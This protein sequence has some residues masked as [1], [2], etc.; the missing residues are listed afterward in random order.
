V[1]LLRL[2]AQR[3]PE[4]SIVPR[5]AVPL[6]DTDTGTEEIGAATEV[7]SPTRLWGSDE[8]AP[9]RHVVPPE[10]LES[11]AGAL[12]AI[13]GPAARSI[14]VT[15]CHRG[16]GRST[17]ALA[18][19]LL[20]RTTCDRRTL[21]VDLDLERP[22]LASA[23]GISDGPGVAEVLRGETPVGRALAWTDHDLAVLSAGDSRGAPAALLARVAAGDLLDGL[24]ELFDT[25]VVDLPPLEGIGTGALV[26]RRC[27]TPLLVVRAGAV[28]RRDLEKAVS[29]F[30]VP[31]PILMNGVSPRRAQT[32]RRRAR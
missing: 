29:M 20:E 11:C 32:G 16:E 6:P 27:S 28:E 9:W 15:S 5:P 21:L 26:A 2:A 4:T 24:G 17:V 12:A 3:P 10:V 23:L 7:A 19:A 30:D 8:P 14:G 25:L 22:G 18:L 31:P 1:S 13:G